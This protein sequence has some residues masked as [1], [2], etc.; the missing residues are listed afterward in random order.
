MP[1]DAEAL[2]LSK[3]AKV[4]THFHNPHKDYGSNRLFQND[5]KEALEKD[6]AY[7]AKPSPQGLLTATQIVMNSW[8]KDAFRQ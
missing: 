8:K 2:L 6:G 3:V 7:T 1:A 4:F 5:Q